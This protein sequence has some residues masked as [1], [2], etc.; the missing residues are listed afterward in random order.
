METLKTLGIVGFLFFL[1]KGLLWLVLFA[2]IA[3]GA[4]SK[5]KVDQI[6]ARLRRPWKR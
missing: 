5:E 1:I 6:K 3:K 2:L 4:V